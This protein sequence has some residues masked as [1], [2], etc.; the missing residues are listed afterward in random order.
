MQIIASSTS[1][2]IGNH[3]LNP[4]NVSSSPF[5]NSTASADIFPKVPLLEMTATAT[6]RPDRDIIESL[7]MF[8]P[9]EVTGNPDRPN[10]YFSASPR[11]DRGEDKHRTILEP[12]CQSLT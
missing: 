10:I 2:L 5:S 6:K 4:V 12:L 9:A 3:G 11:R 7:G 1:A 8:N